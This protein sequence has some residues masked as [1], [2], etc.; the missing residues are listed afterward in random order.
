M[1]LTKYGIVQ[2][3]CSQCVLSKD[4]SSRAVESLLEIIKSTLA[5]GEDILISG[6]G[7]FEVKEKAA[8]KGRNPQTGDDLTLAPRRI[9]TFKYSDVLKRRMNGKS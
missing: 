4:T 1:T 3:I 8:R 5:A 7:K 6:F 9:V 2:N